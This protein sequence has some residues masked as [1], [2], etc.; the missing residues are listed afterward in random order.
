MRQFATRAVSA[1]LAVVL[2]TATGCERTP[3]PLETHGAVAARVAADGALASGSAT[4]GELHNGAMDA[5]FQALSRANRNGTLSPQAGCEIARVA[6]AKRLRELG[7]GNRHELLMGDGFTQVGCRRSPTREAGVTVQTYGADYA[8]DIIENSGLSNDAK[9]Y[10]HAINGAA[11]SDVLT[12]AQAQEQIWSAEQQAWGGLAPAEAEVVSATASVA[13]SSVQYWTDNFQQWYVAN[14]GGL[15]GAP[16][17]EVPVG[18]SVAAN[19]TI[20]SG[21]WRGSVRRI[22]A[23]DVGGAVAGAVAGAFAGGVGAGP[24]A[25]AGG[26]GGSA[27]AATLELL[28]RVF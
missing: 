21:G 17:D 24:G 23:G 16:G 1:V 26:A 28:A 5:V 10:L 18:T 19:V 3:T 7:Y 9:G 22:V 27:G 20:M 6:V 11:T 25:L 2:V 13:A 15:G 8:W 14:G 4:V 12:V